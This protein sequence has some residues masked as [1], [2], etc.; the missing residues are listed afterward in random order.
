MMG[1]GDSILNPKMGLQ[2]KNIRETHKVMI[3]Q[4]SRFA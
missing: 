4:E 1:V 2:I 3:T